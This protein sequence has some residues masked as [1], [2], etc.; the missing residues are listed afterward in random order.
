MT[1]HHPARRSIR[2]GTV[3]WGAWALGVGLVALPALAVAA[4][5][6]PVSRSGNRRRTPIVEVV[7]KV[8]DA[9]VNIH[10]ERTVAAAAG[11]ETCTASPP[12]RAA[13]TAWAP[14][15]SSTRAA[16]SSP[17]TTSSTTSGPRG[18]AQRRQHLPG[19]GHR[20][21]PRERPG[22]AQD[23]RPASRSDPAAGHRPG[24]D[25]RRDR[26]RHRQ[27]LRLRAHGHRGHRVS[28]CTG[29]VTL[30]K[31]MS[32][33]SLIQ[34]DADQPRQLRRAARQHPGR[35]GRR[36][37]RHPGRCPEH[38]L[39]HPGGHDDPRRRRHAQSKKRVA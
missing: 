38:R 27:R 22:P 3:R 19:Q 29:D 31:D 34:T 35:A 33:K 25:G 9:V 16:T 1:Q 37:R 13:S 6:I 2:R 17:T 20:P 32:Y 18:P 21:R 10:S 36:Q 7:E 23:R 15:S 4:D 5:A 28:A 39:R 26:H 30:N 24:P 11:T 14:A 8:K 12:P